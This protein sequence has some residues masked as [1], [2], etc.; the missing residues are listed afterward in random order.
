MPKKVALSKSGWHIIGFIS[1]AKCGR[2][3]LSTPASREAFHI[4][5]PP[6]D[7]SPRIDLETK[8]DVDPEASTEPKASTPLVP[9]SVLNSTGEVLDG[10][11]YI[12][13]YSET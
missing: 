13:S 9:L 2:I 11:I 4:P 10:Q 3:S 8:Q 1:P 5:F 12:E 6:I 7:P